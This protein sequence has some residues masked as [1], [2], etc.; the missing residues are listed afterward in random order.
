[1]ARSR[2]EA[3]E[4][5]AP[6]HG[7]LY[8]VST[9]IGNPEDISLRAL[10]VLREAALI[11]AEDARVTR[12]LLGQFGIA[13]ETLSYQQR[14]RPATMRMARGCLR[15]GKS[16]AFVC[17]AGT[18]GVADPGL[19]LVHAA[20]A[21]GAVVSP[22]PGAAAALAALVTSGLPTGRFVFE[23]FP[24]RAR[25]DRAAFFAALSQETRTIAL[26]ESPAYLRATLEALSGVFGPTH[27]VA[28]ARNLTRSS[29]AVFRGTLGEAVTHFPPR[30]PQGEYT[31]VVGGLRCLP[32]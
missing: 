6:P 21:L 25:A 24:P 16:V 29:E 30:P 18:P 15:A 9:P 13:T 17:D 27:P 26:Y 20:L 5:E 19:E 1:V 8:L 14:A 3:P 10:R 22:V 31:L 12:R 32:A 28:V 7:A 2:A 11:V 4:R 23:G